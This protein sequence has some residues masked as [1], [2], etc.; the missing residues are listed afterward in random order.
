MWINVVAGSRIH[1]LRDDIAL[2]ENSNCL[3]NVKKTLP[4]FGMTW[5]GIRLPMGR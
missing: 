4:H 5:T 1:I 3:T 2:D